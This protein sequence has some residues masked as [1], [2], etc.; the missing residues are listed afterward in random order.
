MLMIIVISSSSLNDLLVIYYYIIEKAA[1]M[2]S[3][4]VLA[5]YEH[6]VS[7]NK[8]VTACSTIIATLKFLSPC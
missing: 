1:A 8:H 3:Q 7:G 6:Y 4:F 5:N 2:F